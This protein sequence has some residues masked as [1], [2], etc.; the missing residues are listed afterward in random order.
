MTFNPFYTCYWGSTIQ[1]RSGIIC[2]YTWQVKGPVIDKE[3][4]G[5]PLKCQMG[6]VKSSFTLKKRGGGAEIILAMR[7]VGDGQKRG[8]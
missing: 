3:E 5:G 7:K 1:Q 4:G 2:Q 8:T 6:G